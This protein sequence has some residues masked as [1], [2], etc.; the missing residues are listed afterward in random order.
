MGAFV[1]YARGTEALVKRASLEA[2][3]SDDNSAWAA[4]DD[5]DDD[6]GDLMNLLHEDRSD[7]GDMGHEHSGSEHSGGEPSDEEVLDLAEEVA[8]EESG[9]EPGTEGLEDLMRAEELGDEMST[10]EHTDTD[11]LSAD[12]PKVT[13]IELDGNKYQLE[14]AAARSACGVAAAALCG[15]R[16][17]GGTRQGPRAR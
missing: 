3:M 13:Q 8:A 17:V 14:G 1:K 16:R 15:Q 10:S 6:D 11:T 7:M 12:G 9:R 5:N 2:S 4:D